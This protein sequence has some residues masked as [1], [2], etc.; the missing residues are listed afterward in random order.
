ML[1]PCLDR[2]RPKLRYFPSFANRDRSILVPYNFPI[3]I[4]SLVKQDAPHRKRFLAEKGVDEWLDD[5]GRCEFAHPREGQQVSLS[6]FLVAKVYGKM[7][8]HLLGEA[9][10]NDCKALLFNTLRW[11]SHGIRLSQST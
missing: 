6:V 9:V 7:L 3:S 1:N 5:S 10:G 4:W 8:H 11:F 2:P